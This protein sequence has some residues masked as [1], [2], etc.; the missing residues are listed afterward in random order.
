MPGLE[1]RVLHWVLAAV[2]VS[3]LAALALLWWLL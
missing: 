3:G 1:V 2:T